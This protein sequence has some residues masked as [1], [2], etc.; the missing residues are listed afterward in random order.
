MVSIFATSGGER[1]SVKALLFRT[2]FEPLAPPC[3]ASFLYA[4][5]FLLVWA[6]IMYIFY[7]KRIFISV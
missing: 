2:L 1:L 4:A 3:A 7:R 5:A 6:G